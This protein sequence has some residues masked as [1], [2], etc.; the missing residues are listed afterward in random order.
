MASSSSSSDVFSPYVGN[1]ATLEL[2]P[3]VTI[4][5]GHACFVI[6]EGGINHQGEVSLAKKLIDLAKSSGADC[7]K[8][9]KRTISRILTKEGLERIY[10]TPNS[11][12]RTYG[13]HKKVLELSKDEF[14]ELK[15]YADEVGILFTA[16]G[17][18][19]ESVDFIDEIGCPFFK[20]ASADLTNFPL[21]EHTAR[22]QK[23]MIIS[24][25]MA[26]MKRVR[27]AYELVTAINSKVVLLQCT[28]TYPCVAADINL[29]AILT[30]QREFPNAVIGYSGH[31]SGLQVSLGAVMLGAKVLERHFTLDR[32]MKGGDH[33]A[34][35]ERAGLE[36][37]IRDVHLLEDAL[38]DG[39][40]VMRLSE[41]PC[42]RKL[43]KSC[44][45]AV[46]IAGGTV[47]TRDMLTTKGPGSGISAMFLEHL[48]GKK[49]A[50]DLEADIVLYDADIEDF[51]SPHDFV[52]K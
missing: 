48:V 23:P 40:K 11:F 51:V 37:L 3:G 49:T 6:A 34:S 29:R 30:Y 9:Q 21:L 43:S 8:F 36:R 35:L 15:A 13:E 47:I 17:W 41:V 33:A 50:R 26:D 7:V 38:G 52:P 25:G 27:A 10:D 20:M 44:V 14:V 22:K 12:G 18:D 31:E 28:S 39:V 16:S 24:T 42:F 1:G 46:D 32:A 45:S 5:A 2:A 19:E 4:G